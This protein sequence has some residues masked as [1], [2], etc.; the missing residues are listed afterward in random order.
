MELFIKNINSQLNSEVTIKINGY[1]EQSTLNGGF[2]CPDF[3]YLNGGLDNRLDSS[4][5]RKI[6]YI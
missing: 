5:C 2:S 4:N 3:A 6:Y 1:G